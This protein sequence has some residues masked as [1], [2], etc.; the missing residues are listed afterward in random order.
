MDE[1]AR[2]AGSHDLEPVGPPM[3]SEDADAVLAAVR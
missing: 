2:V 3:S 1:L